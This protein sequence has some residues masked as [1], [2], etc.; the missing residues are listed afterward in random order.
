MPAS[1]G[2]RTLLSTKRKSRA[3]CSAPVRGGHGTGRRPARGRG[4]FVRTHEKAC[5]F[6][7]GSV[8]LGRASVRL[9]NCISHG[10]GNDESRSATV[11]GSGPR[12]S[13]HRSPSGAR[14]RTARSVLGTELGRRAEAIAQASDLAATPWWLGRGSGWR[15]VAQPDAAS[16]FTRRRGQSTP[17][18]ARET[19]SGR[20]CPRI[21]LEIG[22]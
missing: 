1:T 4:S 7:P 9:G 20:T 16:A 18:R 13:G 12:V 8:G 11:R 17:G 6:G 14:A 10:G 22:S 3:A 19:G 2:G 15:G 5:S 21:T